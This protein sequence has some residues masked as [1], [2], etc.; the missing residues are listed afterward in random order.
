[1][2]KKTKI[3]IINLVKILKDLHFKNLKQHENL[4]QNNKLIIF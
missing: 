3:K 2:Q 1:M 4:F